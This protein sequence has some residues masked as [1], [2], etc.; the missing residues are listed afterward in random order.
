MTKKQ[1][2]EQLESMTGSL[3]QANEVITFVFNVTSLWKRKDIGN[4]KA[5]KTINDM[6]VMKE[7]VSTTEEKNDDKKS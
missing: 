4:Y 1:L 5:I 7:N 6:F 3:Q 2:K